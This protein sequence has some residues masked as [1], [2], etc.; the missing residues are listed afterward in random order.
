MVISANKYPSYI[1]LLS[2]IYLRDLKEEEEE[3]KQIEQQADGKR[4]RE[5]GQKA[6]IASNREVLISDV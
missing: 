1:H 4:G 5:T 2:E 3:E 6:K